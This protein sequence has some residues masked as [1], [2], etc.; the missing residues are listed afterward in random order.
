M[1]SKTDTD[2]GV[3]HYHEFAMEF[4]H[5]ARRD[6]VDA[7]IRLRRMV[8]TSHEPGDITE[9]RDAADRALSELASQLNIAE[10][11]CS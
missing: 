6:A 2:T 7:I 4:S 3:D 10:D 11:R 9:A 5:D 1:T 8:D